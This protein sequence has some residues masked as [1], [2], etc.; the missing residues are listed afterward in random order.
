MR[1]PCEV[2]LLDAPSVVQGGGGRCAHAHEGVMA[3]AK[4]A[5]R[6]AILG[7]C[8][9]GRQQRQTRSC[10]AP[11]AWMMGALLTWFAGG[12]TWLQPWPSW[13]PWDGQR[14]TPRQTPRV[15]VKEGRT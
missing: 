1:L 9:G 11:A 5:A 10:P 4:Q 2:P 6:A 8:A 12:G 3:A 14:R 15:V 13:Q 7:D